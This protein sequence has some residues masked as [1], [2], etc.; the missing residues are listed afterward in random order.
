MSEAVLYVNTNGKPVTHASYSSR[1]SF[2]KC[3]REF[4]LTRIDGWSDKERRAA[5]L[6]GKCIEA[7]LQAYEESKRTANKG[8]ES[9]VYNWEQVKLLP[10]FSKLIFT[11]CEGDWDRLKQA[12]TEMM[13]LYEVKAPRLPVASPLFQKE[14]RKKIFP[15]TNLD[16]LEN[17]A[18]IDIMSF[19]RWDHKLL[20]VIPSPA[21]LEMNQRPLIIDVKTSGR[22][23]AVDLVALDPQLAE[24]A[25]QARIPDVAF[26]WFVKRGRELKTGSR[27]TLLDDAG[28]W[29]AG[30]EGWVLDIVD[31]E[32]D[33]KKP[34]RPVGV[35]VGDLPA[36]QEFEKA[37]KG[38][39]DKKRTAAKEG[40]LTA[41]YESG[42]VAFPQ[43]DKLT[44]QRLQ[45]AAV[46][47]SEQDMDDVGRS[48]AQ[49]TVEMVRAHE[50]GFY[51]RQPGIRFPNEK[52]NFCSMKWICLNRPDQRD[53]LLTKKGEEWLD[54]VEDQEVE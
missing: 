27:I 34:Q 5:P 2:R 3:P 6:F 30:W 19:P 53:L 16:K 51:E 18:Y 49:T 37:V 25:W 12:G 36:L 47:L 38:L 20:P 24:Y 21:A 45:F 9:F 4:Q 32:D 17:K 52:C 54:C 1:M 41:A 15:G 13:W 42:A 33:P 44:K 46:R 29:Y 50:M 35:W 14:L 39:R 23:L 22:D 40:F 26:L 43:R 11:E 48:V 7:G 10:E 8:V 28:P 31:P